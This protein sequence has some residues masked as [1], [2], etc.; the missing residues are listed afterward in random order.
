MMRMLLRNALTND[1][2]AVI[3]EGIQ[4]VGG[5]Q[6]PDD[7]FLQLLERKCRELECD[8]HIG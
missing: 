1:V 2:A 5:I 6:L 3:I 7:S 4:G 8:A